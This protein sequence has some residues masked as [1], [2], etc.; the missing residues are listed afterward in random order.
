MMYCLDC[1][2]NL[3]KL[4]AN[5]CPECGQGFDTCDSTTYATSLRR[6]IP[7]EALAGTTCSVLYFV[8]L[9]ID[10]QPSAMRHPAP[11]YYNY[12][13]YIAFI[14]LF[15]ISIGLLLATIR[16]KRWIAASLGSL[17]LLV[18]VIQIVRSVQGFLPYWF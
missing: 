17:A 11:W 1:K 10:G 9:Y 2:Y 4:P 18:M 6:L 3:Q 13:K 8:A 15:G 5:T 12:D 16:L 7:N 14:I